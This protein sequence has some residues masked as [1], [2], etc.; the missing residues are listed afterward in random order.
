MR[1]IIAGGGTGG[2]VFPG[3]ALAAALRERGAPEDVLF[4]GTPRGLEATAAPQAG[5]RFEA[6]P[7]RQVRGG[8]PL[9][10]LGGG[11]A[12]IRA[13]VSALRLI[14]RF[15]PDLVVGVGGYAA[16]PVVVAAWLG[17][18][19]IVL[20]E[21][22]VIPGATNRV[23]GR[24]ARLVCVSFPETATSFPGARVVC[25]GNPV[26]R[27]VVE[28]A[29]N[30]RP[31]GDGGPTVLV[32]G[33]SAGAHRLN[34]E[35]VDAISRLSTQ[36]P[37]L[38]VVHQTGAADADATRSRYAEIGVDAE[39]EP[40][41]GDMARLYRIA[42][43]AVCRAGATTIAELLAVGI[44]AILVPYPYAA[45]DHQRRN[46]EAITANGAGMLILDRELTGERLAAALGPLLTD[47][48]R[49]EQMAR[50]ARVLAR[51]DAGR[52][53]ADECA[54]L[55]AAAGRK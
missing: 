34:V 37:G 48:A 1:T 46:A 21:Q 16:A 53:V 5:F 51:P 19:P 41:F 47:P 14:R 40:F 10:A 36:V 15:R 31:A 42:D 3:I 7:A 38:R 26:R 18:V 20:L 22:N 27:E 25:T 43:L 9:R 44:P 12:L 49:R 39:V 11:I 8:G 28:A 13:A 23:L 6:V 30:R 17:R 33:G 55:V 24:L 50:A 52:L 54:R 29:G 4:V 2:H 35:V 32:V 45:D